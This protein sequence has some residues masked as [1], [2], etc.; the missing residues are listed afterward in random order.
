MGFVTS[1][2]VI[3]GAFYLLFSLTPLLWA[4]RNFELFEY[5]KMM[6]VYFMAI[7]VTTAWIHKMIQSKTFI[8]KRTILD[9]P[10]LIFLISQVFS[11]IFSIDPHT[12]IWGYYSR[13]NGGLLSIISYLLL[14]WAFVSNIESKQVPKV[15]LA[16]VVSAT[17]ISLW[18]ISEHFG[19]SPSCVILRG[20]FN[21]DC[22]IQRVQERVFATL[23]QPN[24]LSAYLAMLLF[25][26][27][28]F[29][30]TAQK[31]WQLIIYYLLLTAFYLAF[32]FTYSNGGTVG[33]LAGLL[34]TVISLGYTQ[35]KKKER[36]LSYLKPLFLVLGI[37]II[38]NLIFGAAPTRRFQLSK[39]LP[40]NSSPASQPDQSIPQGG[41]QLE[42][43]GAET[44]KIRLIV[45]QGALEVFKHYPILGS[46]VETFA[47]SYYNFRPASHNLTS[48]WD[49]LYNKAHNEYLN[50]LATTGLLGTLSYLALI[51]TFIFWCCQYLFKQKKLSKQYL[52]TTFLLASY[53]SYL[54]QN[55]FGFSVVVIALFFYL[56]PALTLV[57]NQ[58][59]TQVKSFP[60]I[61]K[62]VPWQKRFLNLTSHIYTPALIIVYLLAAFLAF[63]LIRF[64]NADTIFA[65]GVRNSEAGNAGRAYNLLSTSVEENS[66]EPFYRSELGFAAAS[67]AVALSDTDATLSAALKEQSLRETRLALSISPKNVSFWR[68][69]I[70][71]YYQLAA[72]DPKLNQ[73]TLDAIDE[74][75][76]L[77][78]TDPKLYYNK[79]IILGQID[80][81]EPAI[82]A[83][84]KAVE[85]KPNYKEAYMALGLFYFDQKEIEKAVYSM[86]R[87]LKSAPNDQEVLNHLIDWGKKG[88]ATD[89]G[90]RN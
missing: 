22:W 74:A 30:L 35:I 79:A 87:A 23:G 14:Y 56:F 29:L 50:Y 72:L 48:E 62:I 11:T 15:L 86:N 34:V 40:Q 18:A 27:F 13:S 64:W 70:R 2:K 89:S 4:P 54:V 77:A 37:F 61:L 66:W 31:R 38:I 36:N 7:V 44:G 60:S 3:I 85:L 24:W 81:S 88:I 76:K 6:F 51:F 46:G 33:F 57:Y 41:S 47:Y 84:K 53:I 55:F 71:T 10:L 5:N 73:E 75:I 63:S 8:F 21:V 17:V 58:Q 78:P 32:T 9:L 42:N 16:A 45:W 19:V 65:L 12:S 25:P 80:K 1:N 28:Y 82:D 90:T 52:F 26:T 69:A 59:A 83:L 68:T 67:A 49:F 43:G 20:E 39:L